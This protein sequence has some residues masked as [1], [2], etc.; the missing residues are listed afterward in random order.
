MSNLLKTSS[1][2]D[3]KRQANRLHI[4]DIIKMQLKPY[5]SNTIYSFTQVLLGRKTMDTLSLIDFL[6]NKSI[7][8]LSDM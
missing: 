3:N 2:K 6:Y 8:P 5:Q 1:T 4:E 7:T